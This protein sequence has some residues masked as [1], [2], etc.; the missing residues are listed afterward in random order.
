[1]KKFRYSGAE[2]SDLRFE[3][4]RGCT[5]CCSVTG[6]VYVT[7]DDIRNAAA[8][9]GL[10]LTDFEAKYVVRSKHT[11]RWRKP[12]GAQCHF[13]GEGGCTIHPVKPVQCRLFP[14]WPE[15]VENRDNWNDAAQNCPGIG[16]GELIQIGAAMEIANEMRLAYPSHYEGDS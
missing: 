16:Q 11:T 10:P 2:V 1:L 13:L 7:E 3:C 5:N 12:Q 6:W 15:L 14:F 8:F 9:V 4:V